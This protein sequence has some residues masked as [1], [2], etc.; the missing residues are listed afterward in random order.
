MFWKEAWLRPGN[1]AGA[2]DG[3][4]DSDVAKL[5]A[6]L[7]SKSD[8]R[9]YF[10]QSTEL[11][12]ATQ[13]FPGK[14]R[15]WRLRILFREI[16]RGDLSVLQA[17]MMVGQWTQTRFGRALGADGR[18]RRPQK[19]TPSAT[20]DLKPGELIRIKTL[21]QI[22]ETLDHKS[23]NRGMAVCLEMLRL[24][25][26]EADVRYRVDRVIDEATGVM[27][28]FADTVTVHHVRNS[29]TLAEECLCYNELG[30]CPRGEIMYWREVWLERADGPA[31]SSDR[32]HTASRPT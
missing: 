18:I 13:P 7:K 9:R 1:V 22:A 31:I 24:C 32:T 16:A 5:R 20:L 29:E 17:L 26:R 23:R 30:D 6:R 21:D 4:S 11:L 19:R 27:R 2:P 10:C 28:E 14:Q 25:G 3:S 12:K 8:E 15:L